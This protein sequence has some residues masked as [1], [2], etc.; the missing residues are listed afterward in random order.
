[1]AP[2]PIVIGTSFYYG[3]IDDITKGIVSFDPFR[4]ERE[5]I[6]EGTEAG[7]GVDFSLDLDALRIRS[8]AIM[9]A[10]RYTDGKRPPLAAGPPGS[11]K[12]D[13]N[14]YDAYLL[15]AYRLPVWGLEPF[16][17]GE[18][19][20]FVSPYGDDQAVLAVGLNIHFTAFAQLK[21][22]LARVLFFDL[23]AEGAFADNNM[24]LLFSRLAVAF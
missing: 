24:T 18:Y 15:T 21:T 16:L 1:V 6:V 9:R 14:E 13:N 8:E 11:K 4:V 20:H 23:N 2:I 7:V 3:Q 5:I 12:P 19:D 10:T 22:E 17:Y